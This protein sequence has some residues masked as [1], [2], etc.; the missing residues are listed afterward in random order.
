MRLVNMSWS[1][2]DKSAPPANNATNLDACK[3]MCDADPGCYTFAFSTSAYSTDFT[4][5]NRCWIKR[6]QTCG[7]DPRPGMTSYRK[8]SKTPV[9]DWF[10][11]GI[12]TMTPDKLLS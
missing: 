10:A 12:M 7:S 4:Y 2:D 3:A 9:H 8:L 6:Y 5:Q 1:C 11:G